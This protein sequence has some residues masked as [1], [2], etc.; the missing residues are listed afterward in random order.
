MVSVRLLTFVYASIVTAKYD[1]FVTMEFLIQEFRKENRIDIRS[2]KQALQR[3]REAA[4]KAKIELSSMMQTEINLP[5]LTADASGPKHL[6]L[7]LTRA[8]L[9]QLTGEMIEKTLGP[10]KQALSDAGLSVG[11][12]NEIVMVGGMTRMP[13]VQDTVRRFFGK[14]RT[15]ALYFIREQLVVRRGAAA[16]CRDVAVTE[17][18]PIVPR[19]RIRLICEAGFVEGAVEP[20]SAPIAR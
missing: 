6:V 3:L 1:V 9:E 19:Y 11:E 12:V 16:R 8:K 15:A 14:E 10:V 4:E 5:Y 17:M 7:T 18:E 2:D 20:V 13:L